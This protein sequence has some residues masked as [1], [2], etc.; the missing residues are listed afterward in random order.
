MQL[1]YHQLAFHL[2]KTLLPLYGVS[3]EE[4][5]LVE[6]AATCIRQT[7][8]QAG[9]EE[10]LL[11][12]TDD[13]FSWEE[14][15]KGTR[16]LS[17]FSSGTLL[18]IRVL[19]T[20]LAEAA[21]QALK[22]YS[23]RPAPQTILLLLCPKLE[24]SSRT[25]LGQILEKVGGVIII[26]PMTRHELSL[27]LT[28]RLQQ[29]GFTAPKVVMELLITYSEGNLLALAQTIEK[30]ALTFSPKPLTEEEVTE[31]MVD[32]ARYD[33]FGLVESVFAK[34]SLRVVRIMQRLEEEGVEPL[35]VLWAL[36]RELRC[37]QTF[38]QLT[39]T[40]VQEEDALKSL[41]LWGRRKEINRKA[42]RHVSPSHWLLHLRKAH[43]LDKKL[44]AE[45]KETIWPELLTFAL[46]IAGVNLFQEAL[47]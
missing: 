46:S 36:T 2:Q 8:M 42:I 18:E 13:D 34:E 17:L 19:E 6:E 22:R 9:Y 16:N 47:S 40:G 30:L 38:M 45:D 41:Q 29:K 10:R 27:W 11:A 4:Y 35:L 1:P 28:K 43:L 21:I 39:S 37:V 3:G 12:H 32:Q 15:L 24:A 7:A 33:V 44:K 5:G 20:K 31:V 23:Q 14:T 25:R 26:W